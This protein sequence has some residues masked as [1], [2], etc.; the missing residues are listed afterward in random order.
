VQSDDSLADKAGDGMA[1]CVGGQFAVCVDEKSPTY[2]WV[3]SAG[4]AMSDDELLDHVSGKLPNS[5]L[6]GD[7]YRHPDRLLLAQA[8][9]KALVASSATA[10]TSRKW[11]ESTEK[12]DCID[13]QACTAHDI[14]CRTNARRSDRTATKA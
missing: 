14:C 13:W 2:G 3:H 11:C 6:V 10:P 4:V 9:R 1:T 5:G 12:F 7:L 8:F